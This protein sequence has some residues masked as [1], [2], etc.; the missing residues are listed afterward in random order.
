MG[1]LDGKVGF[2]TAG[3]TGIGYA[4]AQAMVEAGARVMICARREEVIRESAS[5]LGEAADAVVCDVTRQESVDAAVQATV[6]RFGSLD[7]AV[8]SAGVGGVGTVLSA[9]DEEFGAVIDTTLTGTFRAMRA[10]AK[11]M[12]QR[13]SGSI[14]NISSIAS[15]HTHRWMTAYCCAKAGVNM[16][17]RCAADD[18]GEFGIRVNAVAPGLVETEMVDMLTANEGVVREYLSR[19]PVSRIGAPRDVAA[20][21]TFLLSDEASWITGQC[22]GVDGGHSLRQGPDLV[23]PLYGSLWPAER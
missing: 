16:L 17:T 13:G 10:V 20:L 1:Q 21:T 8:N 18:L 14:V 7:L 22:I 12:K 3:G 4:C 5:R 2:V 11:H 23:D 19:M 9:T 6:E 15:T